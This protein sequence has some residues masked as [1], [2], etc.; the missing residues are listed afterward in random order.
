MN[1]FQKIFGKKDDLPGALST[2]TAGYPDTDSLPVKNDYQIKTPLS[3]LEKFNVDAPVIW[4]PS[5]EQLDFLPQLTKSKLENTR[6]SDWKSDVTILGPLSNTHPTEIVLEML[7]FLTIVDEE[8]GRI[9]QDRYS[10]AN[11]SKQLNIEGCKKDVLQAVIECI[12][13]DSNDHLKYVHIYKYNWI[14][15]INIMPGFGKDKRT[16]SHVIIRIGEDKYLFVA[17]GIYGNDDPRMK[18]SSTVLDSSIIYSS[19]DRSPVNVKFQTKPISW[20]T[21]IT[22]DFFIESSISFV[23]EQDIII[24]LE[25]ANLES[26]SPNMKWNLSLCLAYGSDQLAK[27]I[28]IAIFKVIVKKD[29]VEPLSWMANTMLNTGTLP[30]GINWERGVKG[31]KTLL[32]HCPEQYRSE[33]YN[34]IVDSTAYD[35][36]YSYDPAQDESS[37][38]FFVQETKKQSKLAPDISTYRVYRGDSKKV[39][40]DFLTRNIVKEKMLFLVVETPDG[41]FCRDINGIYKEP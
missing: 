13:H 5:P 3:A 39:A 25:S 14:S 1:I 32:E 12:Y 28:A 9:E 24:D 21:K 18:A 22:K 40:Y 4:I 26:L 19:Q 33:L 6:F 34:L 38:V 2:S 29:S 11:N 36:D 7:S 27:A 23:D 10:K 41:N 15:G 37:N 31:L 30:S 35:I 16:G 20:E 8:N 17:H